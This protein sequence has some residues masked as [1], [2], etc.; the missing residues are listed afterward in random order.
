MNTCL[1][2]DDDDDEYDYTQ[3]S[4][5]FNRIAER[6]M[7]T[8]Y[9]LENQN[10]MDILNESLYDTP[11]YKNIISEEG[12]RHIR[13]VLYSEHVSLNDTCPIS[14]ESFKL[15]D[16]ITLLPCNHGFIKGEVERWLETQSAECPICRYKMKSIEMENTNGASSIESPA[17]VASIIPIRDSRNMFL[18]SLST[19]E[20]MRHPFGRNQI[21]NTVPHSY[22]TPY[23][24]DADD[25]E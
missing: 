19:L 16:E 20:S 17:T 24:S 25:N 14:Q 7:L 3:E 4:E 8:R 15:G 2:E 9:L 11:K 23:L 21:F 22:I 6:L 1:G 12:K 13:H 18:S 10:N 5:Y